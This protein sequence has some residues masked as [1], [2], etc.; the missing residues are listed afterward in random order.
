MYD[1]ELYNIDL[2]DKEKYVEQFEDHVAGN[3]DHSMFEA[4]EADLY[5]ITGIFLTL[6]VLVAL[7]VVYNIMA[8][9]A[10]TTVLWNYANGFRI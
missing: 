2:E 5:M 9:N 4:S 8:A 1:G 7:C 6:I 3:K 10:H